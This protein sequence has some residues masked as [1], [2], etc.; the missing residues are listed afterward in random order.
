MAPRPMRA[1]RAVKFI[2]RRSGPSGT[3]GHHYLS[4]RRK[5]PKRARDEKENNIARSQIV[6]LEL[7]SDVELR[8][9]EQFCKQAV[10]EKAQSPDCDLQIE[11][12]QTIGM[13]VQRPILEGNRAMTDEEARRETIKL[14]GDESFTEQDDFGG[15]DRFYVGALPK[16]PGLYSA[17][18]GFSWEE[19]LRF[20]RASSQPATRTPGCAT[21][22][23][24]HPRTSVIEKSPTQIS[25][26]NYLWSHKPFVRYASEP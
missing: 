9:L 7:D 6:V 1:I 12:K 14:F 18:M 15:I 11:V 22:C 20:A 21:D 16:A 4:K 10:I 5:A 17:F 26:T 8:A 24:P 2:L 19:A 13:T 25:A 23:S 3:H